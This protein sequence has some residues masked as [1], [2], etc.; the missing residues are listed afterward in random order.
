MV[1]DKKTQYIHYLKGIL[2]GADRICKFKDRL[3]L[4][5]GKHYCMQSSYEGMCKY[6]KYGG[7]PKL[8]FKEEIENGGDN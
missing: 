2:A 5:R 1:L 4:Y 7:N 8:S 3:F 6:C